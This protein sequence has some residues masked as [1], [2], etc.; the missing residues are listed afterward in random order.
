M[1]LCAFDRIPN[2]PEH[3]LKFGADYKASDKWTIGGS[4]LAAS[5]RVLFGDEANLTPR[6]PPYFVLNLHSSYWLQP[7]ILAFAQINNAFNAQYYTFGTF[8]PTAALPIVQAPGAANPRQYSLA[9]PIGV[10]VGVRVTF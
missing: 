9:A 4:A 5:G 3:V 1:S 10:K 8:G 2:I 6:T 7:N